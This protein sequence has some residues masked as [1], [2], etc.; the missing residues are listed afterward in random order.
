MI[1]NSYWFWIF[2]PLFLFS[3]EIEV[4]LPTKSSKEGAFFSRFSSFD[5]PYDWRYLDELKST[6]EFDLKVGGFV[7]ILGGPDGLLEMIEEGNFKEFSKFKQQGVSYLF[8]GS[9]QKDLLTLTVYDL[10]NERLKNYPKLSV[11]GV[12][13]KDRMAMHRLSDAI[14]HDLF[15]V[16]GIASLKILFAKRTLESSQSERQSEIWLCGSDGEDA[17]QLTFDGG[18]AV[19][20]AFFSHSNP[21]EFVYVNYQEGQ[22]KVY[23]A[24]VQGGGKKEALISLRGNQA[25]P[26]ISKDGLSVAFISDVAGRADLFLQKFDAKKKALGKARQIFTA[27]RATEASP[28]FSPDGKKVAFVSDK[29]GPPRV[30]LLDI[31]SLKS[32]EKPRPKLLTM[33]CRENTSPSWSPDGTKL[34]YSGKVDGVRQIWIYDFATQEEIQLTTGEEMKENPAWAPDS[35]HLVYNTESEESCELFLLDI[36]DPSPIQIS[37]GMGQKRFPCWEMRE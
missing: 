37:K 1:K 28:T 6:L 12:I 25:L 17:K 8:S 29:D 4:F 13:E 7:A 36:R 18:Y 30:Y 22:S 5:S 14:H 10:K 20:P 31:P 32:T 23:R 15:Q 26:S 24:S 2:V 27:P 35:L 3:E 33:R 21:L 34:A 19:T 11:S 9:I 16:Q